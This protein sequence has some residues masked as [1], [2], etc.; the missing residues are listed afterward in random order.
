MPNL[1][2]I[3]LNAIKEKF[4]QFHCSQ[5]NK[6][7]NVK[8][9]TKDNVIPKYQYT[10]LD[11]FLDR[12][13]K[14]LEVV[15]F[16]LNKMDIIL[17]NTSSNTKKKFRKTALSDRLETANKHTNT[18]VRANFLR[19]SKIIL[20]HICQAILFADNAI[21]NNASLQKLKTNSVHFKLS[22]EQS[23]FIDIIK[24]LVIDFIYSVAIDSD[25]SVDCFALEV[26]SYFEM[27][28]DYLSNNE[29]ELKL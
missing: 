13:C 12:D 14:R 1:N 11:L 18:L 28:I 24:T 9:K 6:V 8:N 15:S 27:A 22:I 21:V 23:L 26:A 7:A 29:M 10:T 4:T 19:D 3:K 20:L 2:L 16:I 17:A 5:N 25:R